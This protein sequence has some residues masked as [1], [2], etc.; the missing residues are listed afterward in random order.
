MVK[1]FRLPD[2]SRVLDT[3]YRGG[4]VFP[5]MEIHHWD[6]ALTEQGPMILELND[7]GGTEI[8]Q[9]HGDGLLTAETRAF[10]KRYASAQQNPWIMTL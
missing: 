8:A 4:A 6:F 2:W 3:C 5:L 1:G 7:I 9:V 10:L